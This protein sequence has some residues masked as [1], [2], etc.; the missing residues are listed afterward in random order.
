L[1][2]FTQLLRNL[3]VNTGMA[4]VLVQHLDPVHPS[5]LTQILSKTTSL[6]VQEVTN[7]LP[8]EANHVYVIPPNASMG[9]VGGVLKLQPREEAGGAHRSIDF[10]FVSLAKDQRERAI[11]VILSG[12]AS[13]G[14]LGLE[15]IKADGGI[16]FAQDETAKYNSMPRS[17]ITAGCVDL[18]L[19]PERIAKELAHIARHPYLAVRAPLPAEEAEDQIPEPAVSA[20]GRFRPRSETKTA[21]DELAHSSLRKIL[22][23]LRNHSAVDFSLYKT[24]TIRRRIDRRMALN[25]LTSLDAYAQF[26]RR[27]P[28]EINALYTDL[29]IGVTSF[30]RNPE[31]FDI[32]KRSVF[33]KLI[34]EH[35]N[36]VRIWVP[37]CSTGQEAYSIAMAFAEFSDS[38]TRAPKLQVFA[39][40]VNEE[41]LARARSGLYVK[42]LVLDVSSDRLRRFF[43][44]E[45][46]GYRVCKSLRETVIFARQ[47]LL[48][49]PPFSRMH[50]ISC[51]NLLIYLQS[52]SQN[53]ILPK[54]HYALRP[55]G[56]LFLG[57]SESVASFPDLFEHVDRKHK[58]F[59]KKPGS[60]PALHLGF[61]PR[62][63]G[64]KE[65][66]PT[67]AVAQGP[68][69]SPPELNVE[70]EADRVTLSRHTPPGV[71][72]NAE[73][74]VLQFRGDTSSYLKP[75]PGRATFDVLKMALPELTLPLRAVLNKAKKER[76]A[77][78]RENVQFKQA[79]QPRGVNI[80][81]VPLKNLKDRCYLIFFEDAGHNI[82]SISD[83]PSD[84]STKPRTGRGKAGGSEAAARQI[85][86]LE[87]D[88]AETR[89]YLQS[90][91]EQAEAANEELQASNEE[92]TSANEELQSINEELETSQEELESTNEELTTVNEEMTNRNTELGLLISDL[93]NF[94][95]S[96]PVPVIFLG[97]DLAIRRFTAQ[98]EKQFNLVATD[99]GQ[100]IGRIRHNLDMPDLDEFVAEVIST[101]R[102][103]EREVQDR[104]GHCYSLRVLPY[105]SQDNKVDGAVLVLVDISD[106]KR[107]EQE[108]KAA[109]N[110]AE[111]TIR[112]ARDPLV[113]L[114]ADLR[115][116]T[117]NEAF[118]KT[119][120]VTPKQTEGRLI[121]ELGNRQWAIPK[122]R[123][124]L[125]DILPR[126]SFFN[127]FEVTHDFPEIGSRTMLLNARRLDLD[128]GGTSPMI[129][130]AFE[131]VTERQRGE[132]A[133][134]SLAAIVNSSQDAIIGRDLNGVI[135]SWNKSA[136]RLFGYTEEEAVGQPV[137][138]LIPLDRL[139][140]EHN[141]LDHLKR[142]DRI[143]ILETIRVRKDGSTLETS[144]TSSPIKDANGQ[145]IGGSKIV[146][147]ITERKR[148]DEIVRA[149]EERFHT[150]FTLGPVAVYYCDRAGVIQNFNQRAEE[151]W[152]R[153]PA[154]GDTD[155]RFCGSFKMFR[156]DGSFMPHE[157]CPMAEVLSG[158][159]PELHDGEVLI[160]RPGGSRVSVIANIRPTKNEQGE[161]TGAIN[162]FYDI[163]ARKQGEDQ[164]KLLMDEL[165]HRLKNTLTVIQSI[166]KQTGRN[167]ASLDQFREAF[168]ARLRA[169]SSTH[170]LL[171]QNEWRGAPLGEIIAMELSSYDAEGSRRV[172]VVGEE[173]HLNSQQT[174]TLGLTIH[175][176][177]T[178][179]AKYGALSVE[180]GNVEVAWEV[181]TLNDRSMLHLRWT[182]SGG[183][184]VKKPG[185]RG[186]GS[187][188]IENS[189]TSE[190]KADV[191]LDFHRDG[192]RFI[193][194]LPLDPAEMRL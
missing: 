105:M 158:K 74:Q 121:N 91:Q 189:L 80:E 157:Q 163:T 35:D 99:I 126:N 164:R 185:V 75:P 123:M 5:A 176:L 93:G 107:T 102:E 143:D 161:V 177:A 184:V 3:P 31:A 12:T 8:V 109:R 69:R 34:P 9:I 108:V 40:D 39:T 154:P 2:A 127:E 134:A 22:I 25:K 183:P 10:F 33:P 162:C 83:S 145:V 179:A 92:V 57:A 101:V 159:I 26:L 128:G 90:I 192:V 51:R 16:T 56:F 64:Q 186:F 131:D 165:D 54:F 61:A 24:S 41:T 167:A 11:G 103:R 94:Q 136:E 30:F 23:L 138:M 116:N 71:L 182:E 88:L 135:T 174:L 13:D 106:L 68:K 38:T 110:Y 19:S 193:L 76:N 82:R 100:P 73:L 52:N 194:K 132:A 84:R 58:I 62:H 160:E 15:A 150:L 112:T 129:L 66:M 142:G 17:A 81:V 72:V 70:Q 149:S 96:A 171:T 1:E 117:A 125:E 122:L 181:A 20:G 77:V 86:R 144:V 67:L 85:S 120:K 87:R 151:L 130:L 43:V 141:I 140:E 139:Q 36:P 50:L 148:A 47:N 124:L 152:G 115:V 42:T 32:L 147:D 153:I 63:P 187:G 178:N 111:A 190:F 44:E 156:P 49:D 191:Q 172:S 27:T 48:N 168:D 65:K 166:A 78:R 173:V 119:F 18:V 155:E 53:S 55:K 89:E 4:F 46:G 137:K 29:L 60:T 97:R 175:E 37:G 28:A 98:A 188:L 113:I 114:R 104:D 95:R 146:R 169:L 170:D 6:P 118:Y 59:S 180:N 79:G 7:D 133:Y 45:E 21:H 14:T